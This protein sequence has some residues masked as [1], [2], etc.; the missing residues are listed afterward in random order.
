MHTRRHENKA[1]PTRSPPREV[2]FGGQ[3]RKICVLLPKQIATQSGWVADHCNWLTSAPA[4]YARIGS[5][6]PIPNSRHSSAISTFC[7]THDDV[8]WRRGAYPSLDPAAETS[9]TSPI[10][11]LG[12]RLQL[13]RCGMRSGAPMRVRLLVPDA[14]EVLQPA[15]LDTCN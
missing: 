3:T 5:A 15:G 9:M 7:R 1:T 4:L 11:R 12:G 6:Q 8:T 14:V 10:S 2:Q 13:C